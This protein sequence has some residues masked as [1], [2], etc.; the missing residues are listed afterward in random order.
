M[1]YFKN[2]DILSIEYTRK[3]FRVK[4]RLTGWCNFHCPYCINKGNSENSGEWNTND[5]LIERAKK[6]NKFLKESNIRYP[7]HLNLIGGEVMFLDLIKI[8]SN[9][10]N[11]S[12]L[13]ITTNFSRD[14]EY[15]K[16]LFN[17]SRANKIKLFINCSWH[18]E[19]KNFK[20]KFI[21]LTN[22]CRN[23]KFSLPRASFVITDKVNLDELLSG[24]K[25]AGITKIVLQK[26]KD[27]STDIIFDVLNSKNEATILNSNRSYEKIN[28]QPKDYKV[29]FKDGSVEEFTSISNFLTRLDAG[30]F[31]PNG[32]RCSSGL[33]GILINW[34]GQV[35]RTNC[36]ELENRPIGNIDTDVIRLPKEYYICNNKETRCCLRNGSSVYKIN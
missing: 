14:L 19:S 22:W 30:G 5:I 20:E 33:N 29:T 28:T 18:E 25:D 3:V 17:W 24:Y 8:L 34:D 31:I 35:Y 4:W 12:N 27:N 2:S 7:L 6:I 10:D 11:I 15:F 16:T 13:N 9:I 36:I 26:V 1:D 23:N 32:Y 21:Q